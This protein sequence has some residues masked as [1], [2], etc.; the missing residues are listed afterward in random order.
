MDSLRDIS[1]KNCKVSH[2]GLKYLNWKRLENINIIGVS[3]RGE[4][5]QLIRMKFV[6]QMDRAWGIIN[7]FLIFCLQIY[8]LYRTPRIIRHWIGRYE[9]VYVARHPQTTINS[10]KKQ[11][12]ESSNSTA[13]TND[14]WSL[15]NVRSIGTGLTVE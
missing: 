14:S 10:K 6:S 9:A 15:N 1:L 8:H 5:S 3:I 7:F 12:T 4:W 11:E 13:N 2:D